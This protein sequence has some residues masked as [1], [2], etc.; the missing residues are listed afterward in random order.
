MTFGEKLRHTRLLRGLT[1]AK[2][3][4]RSGVYQT[5]I[6]RYEVEGVEPSFAQSST[7]GHGIGYH[8]KRTA[9]LGKGRLMMGNTERWG[10]KNRELP[11]SPTIAMDGYRGLS[12]RDTAAIDA[13]QGILANTQTPIDLAQWPASERKA[14]VAEQA[15][16]QADALFDALEKKE[17]L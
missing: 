5:E 8:I 7:I 12:R 17:T 2:L 13:M 4:K 9:C 3:A 11:A 6:Y 1:Q 16:D 14:V 15:V 10:M